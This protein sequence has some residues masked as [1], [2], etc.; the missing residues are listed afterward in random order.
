MR[1]ARCP[2]IC[3]CI[4]CVLVP[5]LLGQGV[6]RPPPQPRPSAE[7]IK[8]AHQA[9]SEATSLAQYS[10]DPSIIAELLQGW[11]RLD[12]GKAPGV[13]DTLYSRLRAQAQTASDLP[14]YQR[15][16]VSVQALLSSYASVDPGRIA[17]LIHQWPEPP[18]SFGE[19]A[20]QWY[21]QASAR[22][23]RLIA[24][25]LAREHPQQAVNLAREPAPSRG[26]GPSGMEYVTNGRIIL[27]MSLGGQKEE[28]LKLADQTMADFA[29]EEP[30]AQTIRSYSSFLNQL[31][32]IDADRYVRALNLLLPALDKQGNASSGGV[33]AVGDRSVAL[34]W[35]EAVIVD[36]GRN[37]MGGPDLALTTLSVLPGLKPKLDSV[38]FIKTVVTSKPKVA[39]NLTYSL[40]GR[41]IGGG[42]I[43]GSPGPTALLYQNLRGQSKTNPAFVRQKLSEAAKT[44]EDMNVLIGVATQARMQDPDL[45]SMALD[46][47]TQLV[48]QIEP[49]RNRAVSLQNLMLAYRRIEGKASAD[50]VQEGFRLLSRLGTEEKSQKVTP[51]V[52]HMG[53]G[54]FT[55]IG[56]TST[57]LE[58]SLVAELALYDYEKAMSYVRTIPEN[59]RLVA[60]VRIVQALSQGF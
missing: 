16:T 23:K 9:L 43:P 22:L 33:L 15:C 31:S 24:P 50:L 47:A 2:F 56:S 7:Q 44:P 55:S 58:A 54:N 57:Q 28:A 51:V 1:C 27:K 26:R 36:L 35:S 17:D 59:Q 3:I 12:P 19:P 21:E 48:K 40:D 5:S 41:S 30:D 6:L 4:A 38:D 39:Y 11:V 8:N 42:G 10:P 20:R 60:L 52:V 25:D 14:T 37:L 53:G 29:K 18:A 46:A 13:F 45:A 49:P 32:R 34:T